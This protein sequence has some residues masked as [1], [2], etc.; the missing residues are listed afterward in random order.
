M[1]VAGGLIWANTRLSRYELT[2][3]KAVK[4]PNLGS[5]VECSF[6]EFLD[7]PQIKEWN[8]EEEDFFGWPR[9]ARLVTG[10]VMARDGRIVDVVE[11]ETHF[12]SQ[13]K[14][15]RGL[16]T[17]WIMSGIAVNVICALAILIATWF[18]GEY[19]I[20]RRTPRNGT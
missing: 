4:D 12:P 6:Q 8:G 9:D 17:R 2:K 3:G 7:S 18:L 11:T 14:T 5:V 1:F 20:H 13:I 16:T 15:V 19:L 10:P